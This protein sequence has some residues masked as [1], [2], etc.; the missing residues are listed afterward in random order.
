VPCCPR[1]VLIVVAR[2]LEGLPS[3]ALAAVILW[4]LPETPVDASWLSGRERE[5][6]LEDVSEA[7][8]MCTATRTSQAPLQ[9][10]PAAAA[11]AAAALHCTARSCQ[12]SV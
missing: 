1:L 3:V 6:L 8:Q 12:M 11:A 5:L 7:Y 10:R 9:D 2:R 4:L